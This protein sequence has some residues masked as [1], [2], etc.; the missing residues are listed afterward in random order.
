[1][2][3]YDRRRGVFVHFINM[4]SSERFYVIVHALFHICSIFNGERSDCAVWGMK[5][6]PGS[7]V[8]IPLETLMSQGWSI[9]GVRQ[10][11]YKIHSSG[12]IL[13]G[14]GPEGLKR[15]VVEEAYLTKLTFTERWM[16]GWWSWWMIWNWCTRNLSYCL[17]TCSREWERLGKSQVEQ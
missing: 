13:M 14:N 10:T 3:H 9:E 7:W 16:I 4:H 15:N 6:L 8:T 17:Y 1:L 5:C 11:L 2:S 12:L